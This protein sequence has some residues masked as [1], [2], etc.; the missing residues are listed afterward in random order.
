[1]SAIDRQFNA[2]IR[3]DRPFGRNDE[4]IGAGFSWSR[5]TDLYD[6]SRREIMMI[7]TYYRIQLTESMQLSP[8]LQIVLQPATG[9]DRPV[10][11][12]GIRLKTQF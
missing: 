6:P 11:V 8:D 2:A 9:A 4:A 7:E 10:Y 5:P 12:F 1:M 3:W